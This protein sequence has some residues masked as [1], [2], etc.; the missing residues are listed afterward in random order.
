VEPVKPEECDVRS[1]IVG[2]GLVAL[3]LSSIIPSSDVAA[4]RSRGSEDWQSLGC[5]EVGHRTDI[6]VVEVGRKEG[7]FK[8][9]RLKVANRDINIRNLKVVYADGQPDIIAANANVP[10]DRT[11][12]PLALQGWSRSI[13]RIELVAT[14]TY[15]ERGRA[16]VCIEGLQASRDEVQNFR[17]VVAP[18]RRGEEDRGNWHELG[19]ERAGFL[20]ERDVIQVGRKE[21]RFRA[22][23]LWA[24]GNRIDVKE[25][26]VIYANGDAENLSVQSS[27]GDGERTRPLDLAGDRRS[28]EQV[29][30]TYS[31]RPSL[32]GQARVC[33]EG[34]E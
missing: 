13:E 5:V 22:V 21:G 14:K 3:A 16:E 30:L 29:V 4:Q 10:A 9:I 28:I 32:K 2:I 31:S 20:P 17:P 33:V 24:N 7:R 18:P 26:K 6:D 12:R 25:M 19:C 15:R 27:V 23:R 11:S 34:L 8:A 1:K